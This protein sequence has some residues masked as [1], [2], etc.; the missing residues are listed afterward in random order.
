MPQSRA[1]IEKRW[2]K[3]FYFILPYLFIPSVYFLFNALLNNTQ[4]YRVA[5][6]LLSESCGRTWFPRIPR[7]LWERRKPTYKTSTWIMQTPSRP[8]YLCLVPTAINL[9][10]FSYPSMSLNPDYIAKLHA[11]RRHTSRRDKTCQLSL[12]YSSA[13]LLDLISR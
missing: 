9:S 5:I 10:S 6:R 1:S 11:S 8:L 4:E 7:E 13:S 2:S 12:F 3:R